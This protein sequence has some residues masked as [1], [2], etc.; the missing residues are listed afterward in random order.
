M[1]TL[2]SQLNLLPEIQLIIYCSESVITAR[3]NAQITALLHQPLNWTYILKVASRNG[4]LSLICWNLLQNFD[5]HLPSEIKEQLNNHFQYYAQRNMFLTGKLREVVS[6]LNSK[7]IPVLSFKGPLLAIQAYGNIALRHFGDLDILVQP[8][9]LKKS[10]DL[11]IANG[12]DPI[13]GVNWLNKN[14]WYVSRRKD[15]LLVSKENK[16]VVELHWKLSG[17]HFALPIEMNS[18]WEKSETLNLAGNELRTFSFN[19]L[20]IYLCLHGSRHGWERFGWI[21]D[22][23]EL[24]GSKEI[25]DWEQISSDAKRLGCENALNFGLFLVHEF[26]GKSFPLRDWE[27]IVNNLDFIEIARQLRANLF[28][29]DYNALQIGERYSYHLKLKEKLWDRCKLHLHY[30]MWYLKIIFSPNEAD[31]HSF[32]LPSRFAALYYIMRPPRLIYTYLLKPKKTKN[33]N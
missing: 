10:I 29:E 27:T 24:T 22:I 30:N 32:H 1:P 28:T 21:C 15:V 20:L 12:Y 7:D 2:L 19:H 26:F 23:N 25:S 17:T 6:F 14:D 8:K 11:L 16:V 9:D 13:N 4:V 18:L 3:Q 31:E 5:E 33:E